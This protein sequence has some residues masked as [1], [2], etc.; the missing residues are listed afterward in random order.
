MKS[1]RV[2][3][4]RAGAALTARCRDLEFDEEVR[5]HLDLLTDDH[6]R[7]GLSPEEARRAAWRDFGGV[8]QIAESYRQQ[9]GIPLL[10]SAAQDVRYA[11]RMWRRTPGFSLLVIGV[12]ALGIGA[13]SAMF[14]IV[15][16]LLFRPLSGRAS[17]LVGLYSHD[18]NVRNSYR[19][20]SYPNY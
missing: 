15:N 10:D 7:R 5:A 16:A 11:L 13:N 14:T 18:P 8:A 17:E 4:S 9:R 19:P 20:F 3:L 2:W 6:E 1:I 12:L